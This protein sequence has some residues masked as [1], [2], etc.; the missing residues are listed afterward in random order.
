MAYWRW[1]QSEQ[2]ETLYCTDVELAHLPEAPKGTGLDKTSMWD[3]TE[4]PFDDQHLIRHL[5]RHRSQT[6]AGVTEPMFYFAS[7]FSTFPW[8]FEDNFLYSC[9][10][11]HCGE[12]R[13][14][15]GV[16]G[17]DKSKVEGVAKR[18]YPE[19]G[20]VKNKQL[21]PKK[22]TV[23]SPAHLEEAGVD[24]FRLT[25]EP[26]TFVVTFPRAFHQGFSHGFSVAEAVNFAPVDWMIDGVKSVRAGAVCVLPVHQMLKLRGDYL[27][28][29]G[30]L[31]DSVYIEA[32]QHVEEWHRKDLQWFR[33]L[34]I[35]ITHKEGL[36]E[37]P[38]NC[39]ECQCL[40]FLGYFL[41]P[42][43]TL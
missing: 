4:L 14:W 43:K 39:A 34:D 37:H 6:V 21:L 12:H 17:K 38:S 30:S 2:A 19:L 36:G 7:R 15:Y 41:H 32:A 10:F 24:V 28:S 11:S 9:S 18:L 40:P 22:T 27:V 13:T 33:K 1:V 23:F 42:F 35:A 29:K 25:Q 5:P 20:G 26:G 8:H 3:L 16:P 31:A